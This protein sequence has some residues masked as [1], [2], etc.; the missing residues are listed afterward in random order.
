MVSTDTTNQFA[1][2][3]STKPIDSATGLLYYGY[4]WYDPLTGRW[5]PRDPIA[6][7]GGINLYGFVGNDGVSCLDKLGLVIATQED[8]K[9]RDKVAKCLGNLCCPLKI[10]WRTLDKDNQFDRTLLPGRRTDYSKQTFTPDDDWHVLV[11]DGDPDKKEETNPKCKEIYQM[12]EIATFTGV[13]RSRVLDAGEHPFIYL[14]RYTYATDQGGN[15][16]RQ[17]LMNDAEGQATGNMRRITISPN[18][19]LD[20]PLGPKNGDVDYT[21]PEPSQYKR[22]KVKLSDDGEFCAALWHELKGHAINNQKSH[23]DKDWNNAL[24]SPPPAGW[25]EKDAAVEEEN[26]VRR[27][28]LLPLRR[29]QYYPTPA[30][31]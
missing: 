14:T 2:R 25:G 13:D 23:P 30:Q 22:T 18:A 19:T 1:Y 17:E 6:E 31:K 9:Y 8:Q 11:Y 28:L 5:P 16:V 12:L 20:L 4:R 15:L 10:K 29:P 7:R 21:N 3:F 26:W 27:R 24:N